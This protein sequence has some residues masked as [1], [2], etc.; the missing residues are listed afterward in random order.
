M[1]ECVT[2]FFVGASVDTPVSGS[3]SG[4]VCTVQTV[5]T[6][7]V[8]VLC[9]VHVYTQRGNIFGMSVDIAVV[10]TAIKVI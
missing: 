1:S 8:R 4:V 9:T 10:N 5:Y 3:G 6:E 2:L 7:L